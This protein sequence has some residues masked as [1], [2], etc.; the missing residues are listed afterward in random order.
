MKDMLSGYILRIGDVLILILTL[1]QTYIS[2]IALSLESCNH[3]VP[4]DI[5]Y[6]CVI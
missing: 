6:A 1:V 2:N 4:A 3:S 5:T